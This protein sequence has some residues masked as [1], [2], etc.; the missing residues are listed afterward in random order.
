MT[1]LTPITGGQAIAVPDTERNDRNALGLWL[2]LPQRGRL[3]ADA[4]GRGNQD[5]V[6]EVYAPNLARQWVIRE[7]VPEF[8]RDR[9]AQEESSTFYAALWE[10]YRRG[11]LRPGLRQ[12]LAQGVNDGGGYCVTEYGQ[13]WLGEAED[14]HF[15]SMQPGALAAAFQR[16]QDDFGEAYGQRTQEALNCRNAEAWLEPALWS[17]RRLKASS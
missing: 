8:E 11:L 2:A 14:G 16:F 15:I 1:E 6:Y 17:A 9:R 13:T 4:L 3:H 7:R 5:Y 12:T 10:L